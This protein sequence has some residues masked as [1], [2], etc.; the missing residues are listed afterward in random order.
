MR[1]STLFAAGAAALALLGFAAP[2]A[3]AQ[4]TTTLNVRTCG[5]T[6]CP[7]IAVIR[8]GDEVTI[9]GQSGGWCELARP[10]G[11]ASCRYLDEDDDIVIPDD[12]DEPVRPDVSVSFSIPGFSF[13]IGSGG[14][15]VGPVRPGRPGDRICFYE[16]VNYEGSRFC[17]EPGDRRPSLGSWNDRI[18]SIRVFGDV[19]AQVCEHNNYD[20]RCV[21]IDRNVRNL[22]S[23][24]NDII[25]SIRVRGGFDGGPPPD[26]RDRVCFYE[27]VNYDGRSFCMEPGERRNTLGPWNDRIS[28]IRVFGDAEAVVCEHSYFDGRCATVRSN[29]SS[30]GS[31]NN[32]IISSIRV[33]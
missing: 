22:G 9:V 26:R 15:E 20:G 18:S 27:H 5:S 3:A 29:Q 24:G 16:H 6:T 13:S 7:V 21:I 31:R 30:L 23:R 1:L 8:P 11:W 10:R 32:D 33:R 4:P 14:F 12:D 28:S 19:E 25:S 2:V 17:L